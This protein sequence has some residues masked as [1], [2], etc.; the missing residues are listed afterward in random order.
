MIDIEYELRLRMWLNHGH[1]SPALYGDDGE[2]QCQRCRPVGLKHWDWKRAPLE[3]LIQQEFLSQQIAL[4]E[5]AEKPQDP[6]LLERMAE[7]LSTAP[8][9]CWNHLECKRCELMAEYKAQKGKV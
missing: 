7:Y 6:S 2:M 5:K 8:C 9:T 3:E 4:N 1:E